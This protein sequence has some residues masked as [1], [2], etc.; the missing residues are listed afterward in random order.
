MG[1]H[2][3]M[4]EKRAEQSERDLLQWKKVRFLAGRVG[5]EISRVT[6]PEQEPVWLTGGI[7]TTGFARDEVTGRLGDS[8]RV[9]VEKTGP[10]GFAHVCESSSV[11]DHSTVSGPSGVK[12]SII[13]SCSL[14]PR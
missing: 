5:G 6:L 1:E 4:T 7:F 13:L 9:T 10:D 3:S 8:V 12:R 11:T 2:A 14:D